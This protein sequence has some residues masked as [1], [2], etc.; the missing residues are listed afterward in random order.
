MKIVCDSVGFKNFLSFGS[1]WQDIPLKAGLNSVTGWDVSRNKSN[2]A[3]KSS[4]LESIIFALYGKTARDIKKEQI[5]NWKNKKQCEVVFRFQIND[6]TYEVM[7][8]IKPD[9]TEFYKNGTLIDQDAHVKDYQKMF[10][11]DIFAMDLK[12]FTSLVHSN[13]NG[14]A[15]IMSMK[16]PEKR[17]LMERMFDLTIFSKMNEIC[18]EKLRNIESKLREKELQIQANVNRISKADEMIKQFQ[19]EIDKK[20]RIAQ[21]LKDLQE[22]FREL[23]AD[24]PD[25]EVRIETLDAKI[26]SLEKDLQ[27]KLS[28]IEKKE[29]EL[30]TKRK[31]VL[32]EIEDAKS[33]EKTIEKNQRLEKQIKKLE[34]EHGVPDQITSKI[35]RLKGQ[36]TEKQADKSKYIDSYHEIDKEISG[37]KADLK[38][39]EKNLELLKEGKCPVCGTEVA[40][41]QAH[42]GKEIGACKRKITTRT[43]KLEKMDVDSEMLDSQLDELDTSIDD[44]QVQKD[45]MLEL[46][47]QIE[48]VTK[49]DT[50]ELNEKLTK[51]DDGLALLETRK[52]QFKEK[53]A[54]DVNPVHNQWKDLNEELSKINRK[55]KEVDE[56]KT[57]VEVEKQNIDSFDKMIKEQEEEKVLIAKQSEGI[58]ESMSKVMTIKDYLKAIKGLL[59][60]EMIKQHMISRI[61]P[62]LNKQA[63]YYLSEVDYA[64]YVDIDRWL[65]IKIKGPGISK[66]TYASLS[67]GERRGIDLA[68]QLGFLD[69]ARTQAGI[70]PDLLTFDELLDSSID[71]QGIGEVLKIV[72]V[73]QREVNGKFFVISHRS[74]IDTELIDN[75]YN[76]IK[77]N[78]YSRIEI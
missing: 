9:K 70:F 57:K 16:K 21:E 13:T 48:K 26:V 50:T 2:G 64:F 49:Q 74:E 29:V 46:R 17:Q 41:P 27:N 55:K 63:N 75:N 47:V 10:E 34:E 12:M 62:Y 61:M 60:D 40:D 5:I 77:E 36:R 31:Q 20:A 51:L 38:T 65:D 25:I 6:N 14:S 45:R 72:K 15:N 71:G 3:G 7:R 73:K 19:E 44:L 39:L 52:K 54:T 78:G 37:F 1:K 11:E 32:K 4:F 76:V 66:A 22:V 35:E 23:Q 56:L 67:G 59:K 69:I 53:T 43:K 18:N 30:E 68:I 33:L 58:Q 42:Y 28:L 24:H 8:A